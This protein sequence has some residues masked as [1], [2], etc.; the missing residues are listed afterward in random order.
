VTDKAIAD[1]AVIGDTCTTA[2]I[3]RDGSLADKVRPCDI[4]QRDAAHRS[5]PGRAAPHGPPRMAPGRAVGPPRAVILAATLTLAA[6]PVAAQGSSGNAGSGLS[7]SASATGNDR[8][9]GVNNGNY[10]R[11]G[12]YGTRRGYSTRRA[13]RPTRSHSR[14]SMRLSCAAP[15]SPG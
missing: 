10:R 6:G 3:A 9:A 15:T 5:E 14:R 12:G 2:L 7:P 8:S 1:Y 13:Y 11:P 4:R